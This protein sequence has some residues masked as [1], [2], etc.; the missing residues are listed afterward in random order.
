M[1]TDQVEPDAEAPAPVKSSW[2]SRLKQGLS[3]TGKTIGGLFVGV[4]GDER[5]FEE[6][7]TALIMADAGVD[8]TAKLLSDLRAKVKK[9]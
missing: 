5:L 2:L 6:L 3:R 4:K 8:A 7:E 9:E 1:G